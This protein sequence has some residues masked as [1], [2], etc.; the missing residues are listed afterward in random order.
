MNLY[1]YVGGRPTYYLDPLELEFTPVDPI[2]WVPPHDPSQWDDTF[3]PPPC[4]FSEVLQMDC[5]FKNGHSGEIECGPPGSKPLPPEPPSDVLLCEG[6]L[7]SATGPLA[8]CITRMLP[9]PV[10]S[11]PPPYVPKPGDPDYNPLL[12]PEHYLSDP[13]D[14]P[15]LWWKFLE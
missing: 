13:K 3:K 10:I 11:Q 15:S 14:W 4:F 1:W 5:C 8:R 6:L 9:L 7:C 12:D 2:W